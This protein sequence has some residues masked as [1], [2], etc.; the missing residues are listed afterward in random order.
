MPKMETV[1]FQTKISLAATLRHMPLGSELTISNS[2]FKPSIV[3]NAASSLKKKE[4]REYD[5]SDAGR[6]DDCVVIRLK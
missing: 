1:K 2:M 6:I 5:V 3:R 4:G